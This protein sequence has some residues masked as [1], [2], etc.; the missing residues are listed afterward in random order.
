MTK[1]LLLVPETLVVAGAAAMLLLGRFSTSRYRRWRSSLPAVA[2][3]V[4]LIAAAVELRAGADVNTYFGGALLVDRFGLFV[5]L[6]V[7]LA[8]AAGIA[9]AD[10]GAED[11]LALGLAMPMLAAFGVM[12]VASSGDFV[13]VWAGLELA[14]A[15]GVVMLALR[16][17]DAG[18]R[19]LLLSAAASALMLIGLGYVYA[20][21][22]TA[23]LGGVHGALL[24]A[25]PTLPLALP[26][27]VL[28]GALIYRAAL[29]PL[30]V[31]AAHALMPPSPMSIGLVAGLAAAA[32]VVAAVKISVA[33]GPVSAVY[34]PYIEI[35]AALAMAGGGAAAMAVRAPRARLAFLAAGQ[36]GWVI[37]GLG[38]E[39]RTGVGAAVFLLGALVVAA[40]AAPAAAGGAGISELAVSGLATLRPARAAALSLAMLS[41]AGAPPLAG[42]FGEF[43]IAAAL[44]RSGHLEL[45]AVG[46][47]GSLLSLVAAVGTIR[48]LYLQNPPE[49]GRRGLPALPVWTRFSTL[50]AVALCAVIAGYGLFANPIFSLADQGAEALG[51]K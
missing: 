30:Q 14:G 21:V 11:S 43:T 36:T 8:T 48:V 24:G 28:L 9:V 34:S 1:Y 22:G 13:G 10:W 31:G 6:A 19:L 41:L 51:L 3:A 40:T 27:L 37:A 12:V 18:L 33:V 16:R 44:A 20:S 49:E 45:L 47:L 29:A 5:K 25:A 50:G 46:L 17:P 39:F 38:T 2:V 32:A 42:F 7:L 35:V 23:E 15:A 26:V 4:L